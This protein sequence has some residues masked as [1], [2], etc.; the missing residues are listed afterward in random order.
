MAYSYTERKRIRKSFGTRDSVLE[1]PYLLQMQ[2]DAYTAFLQAGIPP[3]KRTVEGLQAAFDDPDRLADRFAARGHVALLQMHAR[4]RDG[5]PRALVQ[6]RDQP[7][8]G[9]AH[10][11]CLDADTRVRTGSSV[12][13]GKHAL[14]LVMRWLC[15][16]R[17]PALHDAALY[18]SYRKG[19]EKL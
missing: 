1:V 5:L 9:G 15:G 17:R 6:H 16:S 4:K 12:S 13:W 7:V 18:R 19:I 10:H 11:P 8:R 3:Q 2:K 14:L